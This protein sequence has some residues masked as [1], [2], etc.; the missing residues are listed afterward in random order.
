MPRALRLSLALSLLWLLL[1]SSALLAER[2]P[3]PWLNRRPPRTPVFP[4]LAMTARALSEVLRDGQTRV[5]DVRGR[6]SYEQGHLPGA[7]HMPVAETWLAAIQAGDPSPVSRRLAALG[8]SGEESIVLVADENHW[9]ELGT[10]FAALEWAGCRRLRVLDGGMPAWALAGGALT[11]DIPAPAPV[12]FAVQA[13]DSILADRAWVSARYGE[14]GCEIV[15]LRGAERWGAARAPAGDK[16]GHIPHSLPFD[17]R[18][19]L[20]PAGRLP[21]PAEARQRFAELGPRPREFVDIDA[22]FACYGE[23]AADLRPGLAYLLLRWMDVRARIYG[24]GWADWRGA[25]DS[26]IVRILP[27]EEL[28]DML[29]ADHPNLEDK[30]PTSLILLDLRG[31]HDWGHSHLPGALSMPAHLLPDSLGPLVDACWPDVDRARVPLVFYCYGP[32]CTRSRAGATRAA[33][34][35][36]LNLL[37]FR[38]GLEAWSKAGLPI[39]KGEQP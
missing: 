14:D 1:P 4:E 21:E 15:D 37:W 5:I 28:A 12:R 2:D 38:G 32:G 20:S 24:G 33:R 13:A 36:F 16:P 7:L 25:A 27:A 3:F 11:R 23:D 30:Q 10:S 9:D 22:I 34:M 29:R 19:L 31:D 8:L 6:D 17:F 18:D 26:P 35:G 39:S